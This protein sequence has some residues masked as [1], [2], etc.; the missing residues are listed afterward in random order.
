MYK[1]KPTILFIG[2]SSMTQYYCMAMDLAIYIDYTSNFH[3]CHHLLCMD[4]FLLL[5]SPP[6]ATPGLMHKL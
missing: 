2:F 5:P 4:Q 6:R 1:T 3:T